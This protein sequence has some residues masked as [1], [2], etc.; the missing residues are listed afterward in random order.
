MSQVRVS[1]NASGTGIITV[2]SPNTN[3]NYTLTLPE[4]TTTIVGTDA[5]QTLTNKTIQGGT[6]ISGTA[7]TAS[8]TSVTFTGIPSWVK[9][10][11]ILFSKVRQNTGGANPF[12]IRLGTAGGIVA[13]GYVGAQGYVGGGPAATAM[14]TAFEIYF[15]TA[16][17]Y[18]GGMLTVTNISGNTWVGSGVFGQTQAYTFQI[19][20]SVDL[21]AVLTQVRIT[22]GNG[23]NTFTDGIFNILYE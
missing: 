7:V 22:T 20:G 13:T 10:V 17:N 3:T 21:G 11:V 8:G 5:T 16:A 4:A 14:N 2:A 19:G 1:G 12:V 9:R 15:D 23:T 18:Y 6:V